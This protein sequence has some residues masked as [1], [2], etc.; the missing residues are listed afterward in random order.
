MKKGSQINGIPRS[1]QASDQ[2]H[3]VVIAAS[4]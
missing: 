3:A 1:A 2:L 4:I